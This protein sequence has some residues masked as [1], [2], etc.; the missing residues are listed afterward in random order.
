M[1]II[2]AGGIARAHRAAALI[3][4]EYDLVGGAFSGDPA[5]SRQMGEQL[6]MDEKRVYGSWED[7]LDTEANLSKEEKADVVCIVTPNYL[8]YAPAKK[9]LE[10]GFH[11]IMDKPITVSIDEAV[12]LRATANRTGRVLALTHAYSACATVKLAR[13]LV[14]R[15]K[16][17]KLTKVVA[18]CPQGW[19]NK[20]IEKDD[21]SA[22]WRTDPKLAG[23]GCLGDIGTHA[24]NLS[25]TI[26][27]LPITSVAA[28]VATV[29]EGRG[30][31]DDFAA[32]AC[33]GGTVR[34]LIHASQISTG[35][36]NGLNIRVY[37]TEAGLYWSHRDLDH[38]TVIY[39]DRPR[40]IWGR[41]APYANAASPS[42]AEACRCYADHAEGYIEEFANIY[43]NVARTIR[44]I[45]SGAA[46][47]DLDNDF[48]DANAGIRALAF[49]QA[50]L[51]SSKN[52]SAWTDVKPV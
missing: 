38:L 17:G 16:L 35:E 20:L 49:V 51:A 6:Y 14:R 50:C 15:G 3:D 25:E 36:G 19:L 48:P 39:N 34:G 4:N 28:D 2:G 9:A 47:S 42:S 29:V 31:D 33:W 40:E 41:N 43:L 11:V 37:G 21:K 26:T 44:G 10:S 30:T 32:L 52:N 27:G 23:S 7:M 13:D 45:E 8:H 18:E 22:A 24:A 1:L 46:P 12:D 5:R